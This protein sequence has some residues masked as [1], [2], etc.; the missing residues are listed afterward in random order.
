[1]ACVLTYSPVIVQSIA[2][3]LTLRFTNMSLNSELTCKKPLIY[4]KALETLYMIAVLLLHIRTNSAI[5]ARLNG[6]ASLF[7]SLVSK[8]VWY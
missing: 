7:L 1:M 3:T 5:F 6:S 4:L 8:P 2:T